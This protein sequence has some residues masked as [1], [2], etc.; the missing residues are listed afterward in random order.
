MTSQT[1][2][3]IIS[4]MYIRANDLP[5]YDLRVFEFSSKNDTHIK[6][7]P[8]LRCVQFLPFSERENEAK[9]VLE[10]I[11][12]LEGIVSINTSENADFILE[13]FKNGN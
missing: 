6:V 4:K 5:T 1:A 11:E 9:K 12:F 3:A 7:K 8:L 10:S 2:I 13:L